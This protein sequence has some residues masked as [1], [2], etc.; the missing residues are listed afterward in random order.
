MWL[1]DEKNLLY[2][3]ITRAKTNFVMNTLVR[4]E[5]L[6][7]NVQLKIVTFKVGES[8]QL[9]CAEDDCEEDLSDSLTPGQIMVKRESSNLSSGVYFG[10]VGLGGLNTVLKQSSALFCKTCSCR[11]MPSFRN[12]ID[13]AQD[14]S[15]RGV[16]RKR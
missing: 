2:V 3:A 14:E 9:Q 5:I 7:R 11:L 1:E 16:K 13:L 8:I 4:E 12:F 10:G 15:K 6:E